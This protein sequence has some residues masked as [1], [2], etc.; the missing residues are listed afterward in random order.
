MTCFQGLFGQKLGY[1]DEPELLIELEDG[2]RVHTYKP[3]FIVQDAILVE[4]KAQTWPMTKDDMAQVFDYFAATDCAEA[5]FHNFGRPRLEHHR[6]FRPKH[7]A[8]SHQRK[9]GGGS[10]EHS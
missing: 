2:T 6:L 9:A 1:L 7:I 8:D 5:L 4:L 3:D 10:F